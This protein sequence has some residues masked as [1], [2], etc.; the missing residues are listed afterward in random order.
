MLLQVLI[1]R[2]VDLLP[3]LLSE[4]TRIGVQGSTVLDCDGALQVLG[5]ASVDAPPIFA[6]LRKFLNPDQEHN[7]MVL[8]VTSEEMYPA[9]RKAVG[10]VIGDIEAPGTGIIFTVPITNVEGLAKRKNG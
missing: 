9:L 4:F 2:Q 1:L 8:T 6:S 7:K 5:Q 10:S 3:E